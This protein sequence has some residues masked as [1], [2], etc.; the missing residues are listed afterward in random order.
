MK[1]TIIIWVVYKDPSDFPGQFCAR[2]FSGG[3][4]TGHHYAHYNLELVREWISRGAAQYGVGVPY[5]MARHHHDDPVI[6]E[7]WV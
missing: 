1:N 2:I 3:K 5:R 4:P 7:T 6:F